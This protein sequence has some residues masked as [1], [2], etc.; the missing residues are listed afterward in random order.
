M[1]LTHQTYEQLVANLPEGQWELH[2]GQLRDKPSMG[3]DHGTAISYLDHLLQRQLSWDD[4]HVRVNHARLR[5]SPET[6]YIP[7]LAVIPGTSGPILLGR[8]E[9]LDLYESPLPLDVEVW[10]PS[11]GGYDVMAK[12]PAYQQRGDLEIWFLH[13]Y[14]RT[15]MTWQ[16]Q[17][18]GTYATAIHRGSVVRPI[19]LPNVT[20]DQEVLFVV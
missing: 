10:S 14:E 7:D 11:T 3:C 9:V 4:F 20:V 5:R 17:P 8:P 6:V 1:V 15:L 2:E 16:R 12:L 19:A 18:N 13:P